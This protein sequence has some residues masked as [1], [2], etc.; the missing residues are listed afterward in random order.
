MP[1][2]FPQNLLGLHRVRLAADN[3]PRSKRA[4]LIIQKSLHLAHF[5]SLGGY[6]YGHG[7]FI[8]DNILRHVVKLASD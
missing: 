2:D 6:W 1:V 4:S 7:L 8:G 3:C 5:N